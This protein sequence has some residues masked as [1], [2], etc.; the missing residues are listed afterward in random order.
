VKKEG[1]K[2]DSEW[3]YE[4]DYLLESSGRTQPDWHIDTSFECPD[5]ITEPS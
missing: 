1:R 2:A 5:Q 4:A 3:A